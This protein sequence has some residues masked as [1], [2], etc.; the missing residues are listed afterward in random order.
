MAVA[1]IEDQGRFLIS[2]RRA[3]DSFGGCWEFPGGKAKGKET[4]ERCLVRE[5]Q[6]ELGIQVEALKK[7]MVVT[8][9][10]THQSIRLHCFDCRVVSG[11]PEPRA[12]E[13]FRWVAP[14]E[15][16]AFEFPPAN[17]PL[18]ESLQAQ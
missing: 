7:R 15:F 9:R 1:L 13:E 4:I 6:E 18:L 14:K 2:R 8:H 11:I 3:G 16:S 10:T 12:C 5:I 17:R